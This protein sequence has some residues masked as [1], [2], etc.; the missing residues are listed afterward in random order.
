MQVTTPSWP[1]SG[2]KDHPRKSDGNTLG[3]V[4]DDNVKVS[5]HFFALKL[6]VTD[7]VKVLNAL[8]NASV[9]TDP[10]NPQIVNNGGTQQIQDLVG[11]LGK[12]SSSTTYTKE[13]L[14]S[15][16]ELISKPSHLNVPPWQLISYV[17]GRVP[18][19]AATW[20]ADPGKIYTTTAD[21]DVGCWDPSL[22]D[23]PGAVQIA[24]TGQWQGKKF[25]LNGGPGTNSNHA[26]IGVSM[27]GD[28]PYVIFGDENQQGLLTGPGCS[29]SQ[30]GRGGLFYV[31]TDPKLHTA[32]S[33]L[34]KGD[35]APMNAPSSEVSESARRK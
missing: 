25:G 35:S 27:S 19:R 24:T 21:A 28:A 33:E 6:T 10:T 12:K 5:Q 34:I 15:S 4:T 8:S 13:I 31:I 17:L 22:K 18:L 3:C 29:K 26:K 9:V 30:N 2:N 7:V 23:H 11:R 20:W 1:A 16:V 14:S 32:V